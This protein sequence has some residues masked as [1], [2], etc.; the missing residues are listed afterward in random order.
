[1]LT[2]KVIFFNDLWAT[3]EA[4]VGKTGTAAEEARSASSFQAS[5][6]HRGAES[7]SAGTDYQAS[8]G[9]ASKRQVVFLK[10]QGT[11]A[12]LCSLIARC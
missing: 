8:A 9:D 4:M 11:G 7:V 2:V 10:G 3:G 5:R 12:A 6:T 1:M